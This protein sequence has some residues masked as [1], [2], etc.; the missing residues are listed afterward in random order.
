MPFNNGPVMASA[1]ASLVTIAL[2]AC[3]LPAGHASRISAV[4]ALRSDE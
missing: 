4:D 1:T 2:I 3:Y